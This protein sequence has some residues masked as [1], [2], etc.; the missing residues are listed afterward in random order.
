V[1]AADA[2]PDGGELHIH[3]GLADGEAWVQ[4]EDTGTGIAAEIKE[5]IFEPFFTTKGGAGSGLGLAVVHGIVSQHGGRIEVAST[6]GRGSTFTV[7]LPLFARPDPAPPPAAA[8]HAPAANGKGERVLLVEDEEAVR[9]GLQQSL[10]L[11]GY[12]VTAVDSAEA[13]LALPPDATFG[14]LLTDLMLPGVHGA[15]LAQ[16][17]RERWPDLAVIV[18]SGYAEDEAVRRGLGAGAVH[19]LQK[20]F[21]LATLARTLRAALGE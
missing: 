9:A 1:N 13:A 4:V 18:M 14:V 17:L 19:F 16:R 7:F 12:G 20:P 15:E 3:T 11:L 10:G 2:M 6:P 8:V 21:E 5:R